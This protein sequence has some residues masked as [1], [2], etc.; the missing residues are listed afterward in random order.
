MRI[1]EMRK[2]ALMTQSELAEKIGVTPQVL[3]N[4]E[5]K[6]RRI[7]VSLLVPIADA[8]NCTLDDLF[9]D[10]LHITT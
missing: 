6:K 5:N 2:A 1:R 8:L 4:Y 9:G 10:E 7:P 3:S